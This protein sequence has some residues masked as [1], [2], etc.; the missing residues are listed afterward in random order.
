LLPGHVSRRCTRRDELRGDHG[1]ERQQELLKREFQGAGPLAVVFYLWTHH[2]HED[3]D[4]PRLSCDTVKIGL[5]C[6]LIKRVYLCRRGDPAVLVN[7]LS[8]LL[9]GIK[10]P[11]GEKEPGPL[12][13][14]LLGHRLPYGTTRVKN[15]GVLA[16]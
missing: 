10:V 4:A 5:H 7:L 8:H 2:I 1:G 15:D 9:N 6:L 12:D 13:R 3:I 16:G 11:A 14:K